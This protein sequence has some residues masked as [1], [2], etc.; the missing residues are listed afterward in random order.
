MNYN[1]DRPLISIHIPKCAG[2]SFHLQVLKPW[3][4]DG[5]L[6]HYFD[7]KNGEMPAR[8]PCQAG[9]CIHGHFNKDRGF[10]VFDYYPDAD[11]LITVVRDPFEVHLSN[12]FYIKRLADEAYRN[13]SVLEAARDEGYSIERYL[14]EN[15]SFLLQHFPF[16]MTMDNYR[17]I[18]DKRYL[19]VGVAERLQESV[20]VLADTLALPRAEVELYNE[21]PRTEVIPDGAREQFE[22]QHPL[23]TQIYQYARQRLA[24]ATARKSSGGAFDLAAHR[25]TDGYQQDSDQDQ[26]VTGMKEGNP[27]ISVIVTTHNTEDYIAQ[28]L[29]SLLGQTLQPHEIIVCDDASSDGTLEI[30]DDYAARIPHQLRVIKHPVNIGIPANFNSG[31]RAAN[32]EYVSMIAGDDAWLPGKL[33]SEYQRIVETGYAWAYS[34][35]LLYWDDLKF[36][37]RKQPFWG[38]QD[39]YEGDVFESV[40][41][42]TMSLRNYLIRKDAMASLGFFDESFG[43]YED[44]DF[45]LR[46]SKRYPV[47]HVPQ[48]NVVYLQH[49]AGISRASADRQLTEAA[50]V[51]RKNTGLLHDL[52][53]EAAADI[54]HEA[55]ARLL[56]SASTGAANGEQRSLPDSISL[57]YVAR[58]YSRSGEGL[59]F[60]VSLQGAALAPLLSLVGQ[61]P[62]VAVA[63]EP[64]LIAPVLGVLAQPGLEQD[65]PFTGA[66]DVVVEVTREL[67]Y[68]LYSRCLK[69]TGRSVLVDAVTA[70]EGNFRV[71][72]EL[73]PRARFM[74]F[75]PDSRAVVPATAIAGLG[76]RSLFGTMDML[77]SAD[78]QVVQALC[79]FL[80][81]PVAPSMLGAGMAAP[82]G[83]VEGAADMTAAS[84]NAEGEACFEQ[85]DLGAAEDKFRKALQ[86][87]RNYPD[88]YNNL[89]V[90]HWHKQDIA[91]ALEYFASGLE[92]APDHRDLVVNTAEV[93]ASINQAQEAAALCE[94]YLQRHPEDQELR[95]LADNLAQAGQV[96]ACQ[97][98]I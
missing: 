84:L 95:G 98:A 91:A 93:L 29:D 82:A 83:T 79:G 34:K 4:G 33:S 40:F 73:L 76:S 48:F 52:V 13:G 66:G 46:M 11:Q 75:A 28:C 57:P 21:S 17:E 68:G 9:T 39:G 3:F 44:W 36:P 23:E 87:D 15:R 24:E 7:E 30:V 62:D 51:I 71:L 2:S 31:F 1:R 56:P 85:G 92:L 64:S 63:P 19:F 88:S 47:A 32:G 67:I 26:G 61:Q 22:K 20:D 42:R 72:A 70:D 53:P 96:A 12:Y 89:G 37:T 58:Q 65:K 14:R 35:V 25:R 59:V 16:A 90:L 38:T 54:R 50:K 60:A 10:G 6:L 74:F 41:R 94:I 45:N 80:R 5:L 81:V 18:L 43:M 49:K 55:Y 8:H 27:R 69:S 86:T 77:Q 97:S 78:P